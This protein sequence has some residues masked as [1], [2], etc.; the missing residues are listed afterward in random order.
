MIVVLVFLCSCGVAEKFVD[1]N[2][3]DV[4][5]YYPGVTYKR[6]FYYKLDPRAVPI[7]VLMRF[8]PGFYYA[9]DIGVTSDEE[10]DEL[11]LTNGW[12]TCQLRFKVVETRNDLRTW[13]V[14]EKSGSEAFHQLMRT[15]A[16][17]HHLTLIKGDTSVELQSNETK[18]VAVKKCI[19]K[20]DNGA[21]DGIYNLTFA[22]NGNPGFY[23]KWAPEKTVF[24]RLT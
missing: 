9:M 3:E 21:D 13:T 20:T 12:N 5:L 19:L 10:M 15:E 18:V 16:S 6:G 8:D 24:V 1:I 2:P 22:P 23:V 11:V 17:Y 7:T 4:K 14:D